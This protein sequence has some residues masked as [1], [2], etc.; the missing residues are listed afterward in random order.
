MSGVFNLPPGWAIDLAA[1][2]TGQGIPAAP[3]YRFNIG[4]IVRYRGPSRGGVLA[5]GDEVEI[6]RQGSDPSYYI[7]KIFGS[8]TNNTW[9]AADDELEPSKS[10]TYDPVYNYYVGDYPQLPLGLDSSPVPDYL[11]STKKE[12]KERGECVTCGKRLEMSFHGLLD[13][14]CTPQLP[15]RW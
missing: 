11:E 15:A 10:R 8:F 2:N 4:D 7:I 1:M 12:R 14:S 6:V 3:N 13:C 5:P 9:S